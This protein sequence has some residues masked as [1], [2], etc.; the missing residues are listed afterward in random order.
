M[1]KNR[2]RK[3]VFLDRDGTINE[4]PGYV[5]DPSQ[6][7]LIPRSGE[8]V[9]A[10]VGHGFLI[11]V[12]SNQSGIARGI[13]PVGMISTIHERINQLLGEFGG[14]VDHFLYCPHH[15]DERCACRKPKTKLLV[16]A[17]RDYGIDIT[18]SVVVGDRRT[19]V[20]LGQFAGCRASLLVR[21]GEGRRFEEKFKSEKNLVQPTRICDDLLEAAQWII[22]SQP[23]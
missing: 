7:R 13:I 8:A 1:G 3:A 18:Q 20:E 6:I 11:V 16:D 10:L 4:D 9:A 17:V 21:T 23:T 15:P 12:V 19:D 2:L 5:S 14:R 22:Q